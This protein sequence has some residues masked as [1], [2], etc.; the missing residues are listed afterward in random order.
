[1]DLFKI[2]S[3]EL[4]DLFLAGKRPTTFFKEGETSS[5]WRV[6]MLT[7]PIPNLGKIFKHRKRFTEFGR[8]PGMPIGSNV[9]WKNFLW[10]SFLVWSRPSSE[11]AV[12]DYDYPKNT[13][14]TRRITDMVRTT[15]NHN[16]LIGKFYYKIFG[17]LRFLGY[18]TLTRS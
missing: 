7:G 1:M 12:I 5:E 18:F 11:L 14:L 17:K 13:F 8:T 10:G 4:E 16:V 3:K 6:D 15:P 2:R 9:F